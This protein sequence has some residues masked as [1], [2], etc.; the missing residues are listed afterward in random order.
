[1]SVYTSLNHQEVAEFIAQF[2]LGTFISHKGI[3][4][5]IENTNYFVTTSTGEYV[6]TLF[7]HHYTDEVRDFVRL[8]RHLGHRHR[9]ARRGRTRLVRVRVVPR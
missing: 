3:A 6:L 5:G 8:A 7:E 1:M 9:K 2:D 4:A